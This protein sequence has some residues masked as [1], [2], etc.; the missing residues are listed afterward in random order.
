[1]YIRKA[2]RTHKGK[3]YTNYLLVESILTPKGPRQKVI[4]SLGDLSPRPRQEWLALAHKLEAA[5]SGQQELLGEPTPELEALTAKLQ[6]SSR[7]RRSAPAPPPLAGSGATAAP[8]PRPEP[9]AA[10]A[11][12]ADQ[13]R[14]EECREAGPVH[15]G[16]QFWQRLKMEEILREAGLSERAC[17]ISCAMTLDRLIH[18]CSELAMPDWIR[19]TALPDIL[20]TDFRELN[21][22]ALYR[23]L[24]RL[25]PRRVAIEAGLAERERTLF[26]L[27][28]TVFLYDL[29]STYFEGKALG[30]R[31]AK[32]GYSR[33]QRPDCKQVV[34]GLAVN[35]DGFPLAHEVWEGNRHDSTTVDDM[36]TALDQRLKLQPG[37]TVVVDRGMSYD[38]D[39]EAIQARGLHYLVAA[40]QGERDQWLQEFEAAEGF[41]RVEREPSPRNPFQRKSTIEV[42]QRRAGGVTYVLCV[43]S[44][45]K[46]KDR[47]IRESHEKRLVEDLEKL[48]RRV[49][50][51]KGKGTRPEEVLESMG[52]LKERYP[53]VARYYQMHYDGEA[54]RFDYRVD[55]E[56]RAKAEQLD[57]SYLLKTDRED[58]DADEVWRIYILLTRVEAAFR[59]LKSPLGERPIWHHKERRVEAHIFLCVLAYHLLISI[60]KTLLDQGVH[61][62]WPSV[63]EI[64]KT[65]QVSTVVL[66]VVGGGEVR[67]RAA[68]APEPAHQE[69]Y[70]QLRIAPQVIRRR[71]WVEQMEPVK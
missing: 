20:G 4:C 29:T 67:I 49:A 70:D 31:K 21:E 18:P 60:E 50:K 40:Q 39:L 61:T 54:R 42:K 66:P 26:G 34:I 7:R 19:S 41:E 69:I 45:R 65:H 46:D 63:R 37:Q 28:Q 23:N 8:P 11:V 68:S 44:E 47:A 30:N 33:D 51:G 53:R 14:V 9:E 17:Q 10:V 43:S 38:H 12:L 57:G 71:T 36:L 15:V 55:Q 6:R 62:S 2:W 59:A 24:D 25:H 1:M 5:L 27:D 32:R 48:N 22:D 16:Y 58:L 64:L 52:R 13:V 56:Q 3:T 35:R